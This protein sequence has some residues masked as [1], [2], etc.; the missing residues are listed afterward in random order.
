MVCIYT[1]RLT[2]RNEVGEVIGAGGARVSGLSPPNQ[3]IYV[4]ATPPL[5]KNAV[6]A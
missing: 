6:V 2:D 1:M 4:P 3:E 5:G